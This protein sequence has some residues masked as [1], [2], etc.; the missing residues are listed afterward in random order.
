MTEDRFERELRGFLVD[1]APTA[2]S[3]ALR[4][5]LHAVSA[6]PAVGRGWSAGPLRGVWQAL[7]G[8][9]TVGVAAVLLI[10]LLARPGATPMPKP[11]VVGAPSGA[12]VVPSVPFV[13]APAAFF[14]ATA[15]ADANRRLAQ[16]FETSGI[17]GRLIVKAEPS[18]D[19]LST[20]EGW[21]VGY[22]ADQ[23]DSADVTAII[24]VAPDGT[25]T[26][27]VTITG[28]LINRAEAEGYWRP[29]SQPDRL[30]VDLESRDPADRDAALDRFVRGIEALAP[31]MALTREAIAREA[32][33]RL[34]LEVLLG[35]GSLSALLI[36]TR[37][38]WLAGRVRVAGDDAGFR[39]GQGLSGAAPADLDPDVPSASTAPST[40]S[41][42]SLASGSATPHAEAVEVAPVPWMPAVPTTMPAERTVLAACGAAVAGLLV[43]ALWDLLRPATPGTPL[44][45]DA[46]SVGL[47]SPSLPFLPV[48]LLC[49][50]VVSILLVAW[51]GG[52]G[53][54]MATVALLV[55]VGLGGWWAFDGSRP[56]PTE[57]WIGGLG[58]GPID[59]GGGGLFDAQ[60]YPLR[61]GDA[62]TF[63]M[64]IRNRGA[65]PVT[66]LGLD[67]VQATHPDPY[68]ASV[69]GL[70]DVP[71]AID[72]GSVQTLS[73][74]PQ[75]ARVAWPQTIGPGEEMAIVLLGRAGPCAEPGGTGGN[76]PILHVQVTYRVLGIER[77]EVVGLPLAVFVQEK[78]PCTVQV[79][80]GT[81]TYNEPSP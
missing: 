10:L 39:G 31:G 7:A 52:R 12:P 53:R 11:D 43:V 48:A 32:A 30:E 51:K 75:D 15:A 33:F 45:V 37:H 50:A 65:L 77:S 17:E 1:R 14:S 40:A 56:S 24:G 29:A 23:D 61:P 8:A 59:R 5:R 35:L 18:T 80:G 62:F 34:A 38:R 36:L 64:T 22:K 70:A 21:P 78:A 58:A 74:R 13:T 55:V 66:M 27:C 19:N 42:P 25:V 60:T 73:A 6:E 72:D 41:A 49:G 47:S 76:L 4:A 9:A 20:P 81:V 79:P 16:V 71:Q 63:G 68:V 67:G 2:V 69:V 28:P 3:P 44:D 57:S 54:R 46:S 26:C